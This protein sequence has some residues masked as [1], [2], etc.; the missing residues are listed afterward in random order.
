MSQTNV[1]DLK[2]DMLGGIIRTIKKYLIAR[3]PYNK[4]S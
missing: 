2:F 3:F 1:Q 4:G